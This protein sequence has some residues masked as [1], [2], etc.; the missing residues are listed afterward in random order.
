MKK[1]AFLVLFSP[2]V[3][4]A[5][6]YQPAIQQAVQFNQWYLKK[7]ALHESP[8]IDGS[9]IERFVASETLDRLRAGHFDGEM[10]TTD[11]FTRMDRFPDVPV[12]DVKV[13]ATVY[14]PV[15]L[16]VYLTIGKRT[17]VDCMREEAGTWKIYAVTQISPGSV[18]G[19][20]AASQL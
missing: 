13:T 16:N 3:F 1:L 18:P 11:Y 5:S 15:C 8:L 14:D 12:T 7:I 2:A 10:Y 17:V 4:A 20:I 6:D 9:G 19:Q